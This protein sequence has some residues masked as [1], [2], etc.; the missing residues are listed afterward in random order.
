MI[1]RVIVPVCEISLKIFENRRCGTLFGGLGS[2]FKMHSGLDNAR[3]KLFDNNMVLGDFLRTFIP[4]NQMK[5]GNGIFD[6]LDE[7]KRRITLRIEE[8]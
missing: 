2:N 6:G 1:H 4:L 7:N 3:K 8:L 5:K